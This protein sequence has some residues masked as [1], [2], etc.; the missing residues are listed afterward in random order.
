MFKRFAKA[1]LERQ[2]LALVRRP[3]HPQGIPRATRGLQVELLAPSGAGKSTLYRALRLPRR[4]WMRA[5]RFEVGRGAL[6]APPEGQV[7]MIYE[8]LLFA[9]LQA[10]QGLPLPPS[11]KLALVD[12]FIAK[13]RYDIAWRRSDYPC[14]LFCDDGVCHNF[15]AELAALAE[16]S[17]EPEGIAPFL[18]GRALVRLEVTPEQV[19]ALLALRHRQRPGC[20]NDWLGHLGE[21]A[22]RAHVEAEL[23][24]AAALEGLFARHGC[25]R[26]VLS[27]DDDLATHQHRIGTFLARLAE[28]ATE[29]QVFD[30][31]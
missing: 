30:G 29:R 24:H 4:D 17:P 14:G 5:E 13:L 25:P 9:R 23:A 2:G 31:A 16:P 6:Q 18:A 28:G 7:G 21:V 27:A 22:A 8:R 3:P 10:L 20:G 19:M 11:R 15:S 12:F 1:V 26:L